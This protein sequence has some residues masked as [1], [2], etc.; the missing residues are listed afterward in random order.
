MGIAFGQFKDHNRVQG[1]LEALKPRQTRCAAK[2][3]SQSRR[4]ICRM[5]QLLL[6]SA[7][8][9]PAATCVYA[10]HGTGHEGRRSEPRDQAA[11]QR[12]DAA[13]AWMVT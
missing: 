11:A 8:L 7:A 5:L 10:Q 3:F 6:H 9:T 4:C 1:G 2:V 12:K 13:R